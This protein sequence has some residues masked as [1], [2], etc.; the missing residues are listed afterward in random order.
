MLTD[1]TVPYEVINGKV[2]NI[3]P[4]NKPAY[5]TARRIDQSIGSITSG[6]DNKV[7]ITT[8]SPMVD[9]NVGDFVVFGS[10]AYEAQSARV[11]VTNGVDP[12]EIDVDVTFI[13]SVAANGFVNYHK[14]YYLQ[15]RYVLEDSTTTQQDA[16]ELFPDYT[17]TPNDLQGNIKANIT[18]PAELLDPDFEISTGINEGLFQEYKIQFRESYAG[19]RSATWQ[20]P[21][22]DYKYMLVHGTDNIPFNDFID[23]DI[24]KRYIQKYPLMYSFVYTDVN[25]ATGNE[26][27]ITATQLDIKQKVIQSDIVFQE[28]N[29]N[30]VIIIYIDPSTVDS[31]CAFITFSKI[32]NT[33]LGQY[34]GDDYEV[35][36]YQTDQ[37]PGSGGGL[38]YTLPFTL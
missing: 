31:E 30:G 12:T 20:S 34:E 13:S 18:F 36:D 19:N 21:S 17:Q 11:L 32:T 22:P 38:P 3:L 16:V 23:K 37:S 7:K 25:D 1:V 4:S 35:L 29:V 2:N 15:I 8:A 28:F 27:I 24:T 5:L 14:S 9:V 26:V 33:S 6:T 10:D